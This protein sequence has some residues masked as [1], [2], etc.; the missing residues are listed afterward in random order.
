MVLCCQRRNTAGIVIGSQFSLNFPTKFFH[1][2]HLIL[3]DRD[4]TVNRQGLEPRLLKPERLQRVFPRIKTNK[5]HHWVEEASNF[6]I[7][8]SDTQLVPWF[9][10][11]Q[12]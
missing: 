11:N 10:N 12:I 2:N 7:P 1:C 6:D 9:E 3:L 4:L 5:N 8:S